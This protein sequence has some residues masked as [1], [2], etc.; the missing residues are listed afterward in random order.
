MVDGNK[1]IIVINGVINIV[2]GQ[3]VLIMVKELYVV[4][5]G[6]NK[7][8]ILVLVIFGCFNFLFKL[9]LV[10]GLVLII[11][12]DDGWVVSILLDIVDVIEL[13]FFSLVSGVGGQLCIV[14]YVG[15]GSN[16]L[17]WVSEKVD[18]GICFDFGVIFM[19]IDVFNLDFFEL[20][21]DGFYLCFWGVNVCS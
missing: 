13:V 2:I 14:G 18:V 9:N 21:M 15:V 11:Q 8:S 20:V 17:S 12:F 3:N 4:V 10:K 16:C 6:S 1:V 7:G 5:I 19:C